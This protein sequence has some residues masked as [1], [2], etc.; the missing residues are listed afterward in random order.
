M[1]VPPASVE[2]VSTTVSGWD[3][4]NRTTINLSACVLVLAMARSELGKYAEAET[5]S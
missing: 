5:R 1:L 4:A 2:E 3:K